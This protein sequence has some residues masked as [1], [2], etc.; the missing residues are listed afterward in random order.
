MEVETYLS[1]RERVFRALRNHISSYEGRIYYRMSYTTLR[2]HWCDIIVP[3]V[4]DPT[5]DRSDDMKD[6]FGTRSTETSLRAGRLG[7]NC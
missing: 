7:F 6:H 5:E 1:H 4:H 3:N 2:G